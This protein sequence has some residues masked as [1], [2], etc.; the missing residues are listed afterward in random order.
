MHTGQKFMDT[1][2]SVENS[3]IDRHVESYREVIRKA[4]A[5]IAIELEASLQKANLKFPVYLVMPNS[6]NG[7][8]S[9]ATLADP[10]EPDWAQ[11]SGIVCDL[12]AQRLGGAK[13]AMSPLQCSV[14]NAKFET[15]EAQPDQ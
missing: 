12:V 2:I 13:L 7:L 15:V 11:A 3:P 6:G 10:P 5:D 8:I 4:L 1:P 14:A 9:V